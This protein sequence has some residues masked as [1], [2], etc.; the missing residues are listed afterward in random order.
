MSESGS[1]LLS[2]VQALVGLPAAQ[3]RILGV[4]GA[5][6]LTDSQQLSLLWDGAWEMRAKGTPFSQHSSSLTT[7]A[8]LGLPVRGLLVKQLVYTRSPFIS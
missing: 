7:L 4:Q 2:P 3:T 8:P 6:T 5:V 1:P